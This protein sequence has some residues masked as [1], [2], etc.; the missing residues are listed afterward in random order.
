MRTIEEIQQTQQQVK[1]S[2]LQKGD[3]VFATKW[4]DAEPTDR[5]RVDYISHLD[6][7]AVYFEESGVIPWKYA[8]KVS[9]EEGRMILKAWTGVYP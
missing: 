1:S 3:Y 9:D 6:D 8:Q 4:P 7:S 2:N 5:W